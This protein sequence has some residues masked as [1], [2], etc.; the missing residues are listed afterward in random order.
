MLQEHQIIILDWFLKDHVALTIST[1]Y[2]LRNRALSFHWNWM[3]MWYWISLSNDPFGLSAL[4][5][6]ANNLLTSEF[7]PLIKLLLGGPTC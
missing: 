6:V 1:G 4:I 5:W 2:I 3:W 7:T